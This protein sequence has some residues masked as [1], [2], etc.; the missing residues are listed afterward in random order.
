VLNYALSNEGALG[1]GLSNLGL[2][3]G[4]LM[5]P[6]GTLAMNLTSL[7]AS[8]ESLNAIEQAAYD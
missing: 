6:E 7:L 4:M 1:L 8:D 5:G 3:M 2:N